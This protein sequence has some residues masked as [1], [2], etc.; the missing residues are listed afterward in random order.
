MPRT[1]R[2][3]AIEPAASRALHAPAPFLV[4]RLPGLACAL[5]LASLQEVLPLPQLSRPPGLPALL[6]GF[7]NLGGAAVPILRLDRLFGL[8]ELALGRYTPLLVL[9]Q[10]EDRL[11]LLVESAQVVVHVRP[12]DVRPV[13][14][15]LS[16]NDCSEGE[17]TVG[18][19]PVHLLSPERVLLEKERQCLAEWQAVEQER[20]AALGRPQ[21]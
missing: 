5:P 3:P 13:R 11:A 8:P 12:Q 21:P 2:P 14:S 10:P 20:L 17:V 6:E 1:A 9:R 15:G 19:R 18:D 4:F 16:F 7:L